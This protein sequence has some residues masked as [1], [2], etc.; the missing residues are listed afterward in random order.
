MATASPATFS[1][2]LESAVDEP[3]T[4]STAYS[5]FHSYSLGNQLL[6]LAQCFQR[7]IQPGPIATYQRWKELGR[8]V[9]KGE[10]ALTLCRPITVK[11]ERTAEDGTEES[12]AATWFIYKPF[13]FVLAQTDGQ[14]LEAQPIPAWDR[15]KALVT[16]GVTEVPFDALNGNVLGFARGRTIAVSPVNPLPHKTT[17]H[18]LAHVALGHTVEADHA[19]SELT[20]RN[21]REVEAEAVA[22]LCCA[23]LNLPG[24]EHCRG[25]IQAWWG[26][27]NPIPEKSAQR[28]LKVADQI[29]KAG[30]TADVEDALA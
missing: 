16:L 18:E 3:G 12:S 4:I 24:V 21:L 11:R 10:K 28:I 22:L 17:F 7:N 5:A 27:G 30:T 6:A 25:Y 19:D 20:P 13:W 2:L 15:S 8:Q 14:P 1:K 9:R 23:A 26:S 29:L